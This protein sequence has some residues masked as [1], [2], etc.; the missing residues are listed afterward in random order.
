MFSGDLQESLVS[1]PNIQRGGVPY[2]NLKAIMSQL[3][4]LT[5]RGSIFA[6]VAC[7]LL[8]ITAAL[9]SFVY[10]KANR[11]TNDIMDYTIRFRTT[12]AA[13]GLARSLAHDWSH[14]ASL[15]DQIKDLDSEAMTQLM[16]GVAGDGHRISWIG[17][18]DLNGNVV[19]PSH[20]LNGD[21]PVNTAL[22]FRMGL[23]RPF[24]GEADYGIPSAVE[25]MKQESVTHI[26]FA[27]PVIDQD[28]VRVGVVAMHINPNW[29]AE[30]LRDASQ[31]L[32]ID[33]Y[34]ASSEGD[35]LASSEDGKPTASELHILRAAQMGV[36]SA[37]YE[38]WP[39]GKNYFS[40]LVPQVTHGD[41]PSFGW[42]M[43][44]RLDAD[45]FNLS[46]SLL[47]NGV[48][49]VILAVLMLVGLL[50]ALY[51]RVVA[52][53]FASL[54]TSAQRIA[55]GSEEYV[56]DTGSTRE[57]VQLASALTQ[58]QLAGPLDT[59]PKRRD[60]LKAVKV[61]YSGFGGIWQQLNSANSR[62]PIVPARPFAGSPGPRQL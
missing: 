51:A 62:W 22:W 61:T 60:A 6:F 23:N 50:T 36:P 42:R 59:A 32:G 29:L 55:D 53:P 9:G 28:G 11:L 25:P 44:G 47:L 15:A 54:A 17:F 48:H 58:L 10:L 4:H 34:L 49:Y 45:A 3:P 19:S 16:K 27:H 14:L 18:A 39:N 21:H 38:T 7:C 13:E 24:A 20:H 26:A 52:A 33:L 30:H 12:A 40:F 5:L 2:L 35:T 1:L 37:G 8:I 46:T 56:S 41:L 31:T 57:I 43:V